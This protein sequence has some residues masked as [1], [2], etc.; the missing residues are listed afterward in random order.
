MKHASKEKT[1]ERKMFESL[2]GSRNL[3][4]G[5][6]NALAL[7][8]KEFYISRVYIFENSE[9]NQYGDNTYE[10]CADGV[11]SQID[12]LQHMSYAEY[13]Y[14]QLFAETGEF[15][16]PDT[17][18]L[19]DIQRELFESQSICATIQFAMFDKDKFCGFVGFDDCTSKRPDWNADGDEL[20]G[21]IFLSQLLSLY[22]IKERNLRNAQRYQEKM[23]IALIAAEK[24]THSKS[25]FYSRMSHDMRTPMNGILG[26]TQLS[27]GENDPEKL[28]E[29][30]EKIRQSGVY[31]LSLINDTLDIQ[32]IE[33]GRMTLEPR[34][35]KTEDLLTECLDM[36]QLSAKEKNVSLIIRANNA[37]PS[38]YIRVDPIRVRQI[39]LNLLSNAIK[40]TPEGGRVVFS[41]EVLSRTEDMVHDKI[42]ISDTGVGMSRDFVEN[43]LFAPFMQ[44]ANEMT[45]KYAGSG[46]GLSIVKNLL[47]MMG[48]TIEVDSEVGVGTT[49]TIYIDFEI[50]P[51]SE[52]AESCKKETMHD[53][54]YNDFLK[55]K[56]IL[57]CEDH[58]LNAEIVMRMIQ[59]AGGAVQWAKDGYES[60]AAF[61]HS[62]T[63]AFDL[64]LMDIRMPKMDGLA[65]TKAIRAQNR[66]DAKTIPIIAMSANAYP[67]DIEKSIDAG[68]NTHLAKPVNPRL[69]YDTLLEYLMGTIE[70]S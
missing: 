31:M 55:G 16:C 66:S 36:V 46:L 27:V 8:G 44:E 34:V 19:P 39:V 64:I 68:M 11:A 12:E 48:A 33:S 43:E 40:F 47:D 13:G 7:I 51:E 18:T 42:T 62:S 1:F 70:P 58:P 25:E 53:E 2:Y 28:H 15:V 3:D 63:H 21:L 26:I 45:M 65:A 35:C 6:N 17:S 56:H 29:D 5:I 20:D 14:D 23:K 61:E 37:N 52:V 24:A 30:M 50:V 67:E 41:L 9:D 38:S 49:F 57:L 10:W 69:L 22:L 4:D 54:K 59:K 32:R 60:V